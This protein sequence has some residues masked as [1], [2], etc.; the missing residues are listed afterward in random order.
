[1]TSSELGTAMLLHTLWDLAAWLMALGVLY[2]FYRTRSDLFTQSSLGS[3]QRGYFLS[4]SAGGL[5]GAYAIGSANL[6]LSGQPTLAR[7]IVGGI[8]GAITAVELYKSRQKVRGSTGGIIAPALAFGI[9]IGR[10]GCHLAGLADLTYGIP[11]HLPWAVDYG[12]GIPRHP[13]ALYESLTMGL[14]FI[15]LLLM[16]RRTPER[17]LREGFYWFCLVYGVQR[18]AW[19]FLKPYGGLIGPFNLF[20]FVCAGL[21]VYA[22][23]MLQGA[24]HADRAGT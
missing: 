24:R 6:W 2:Y 13:V 18:F 22:A 10:I 14:L 9:C 15:A 1:M 19:E 16:L 23:W 20:H 11:S 8:V 12:D 4:L 17:F 3:V 7:S 21:V 5:I